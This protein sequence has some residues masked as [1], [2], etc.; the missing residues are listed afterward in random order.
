MSCQCTFRNNLGLL[1]TL[2][3]IW[4][5]LLTFY[6][7]SCHHTGFIRVIVHFRLYSDLGVTSE[8]EFSFL[9]KCYLFITVISQFNKEEV[10]TSH[11]IDW[12]E[13]YVEFLFGLLNEII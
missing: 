13:K 6:T 9:Q 5:F 3:K 1:S 4:E 10:I 2:R 12:L 11:I 7:S 8:I